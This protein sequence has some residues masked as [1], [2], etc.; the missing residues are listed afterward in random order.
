MFLL[1]QTPQ[2]KGGTFEFFAMNVATGAW[3]T[4]TGMPMQCS[5]QINNELFFGT[6]DGRVCKGFVGDTDGELLDGT[7]GK[8]IIGRYTGGFNGF[9]TP[10]F[11]KVFQMA[12]PVFIAPRAPRVGVEILTEVPFK[13]PSIGGGI[14][15]SNPAKWNADKWNECTWG[16]GPRTFGAWVGLDGIGYYGALAVYFTGAGGTQYVTAN[17]TYTIGGPM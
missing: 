4:I 5:A 3:S 11:Q 9:E 2:L 7:L 8:P 16:G 13:R 1:L 14:P 12:R 10:G 6:D 17:L 15:G